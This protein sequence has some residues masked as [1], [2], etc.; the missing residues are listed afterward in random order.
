MRIVIEAADFRRLSA[1]TQS[2]LL[3]LLAGKR[4]ADV[5]K[6]AK[7][8]SVNW[9]HPVDLTPE[10]AVKL[11][12]GLAENHRRRLELFARKGGRVSMKALLAVTRDTDLRVLS[13]FQGAVSRKLRRL[14]GD[15]TKQAQLLGW[16]Y[17]S[18]KWD[19]EHKHII[20]G[21]YYVTDKTTKALEAYFD[22]N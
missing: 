2:E 16:D 22:A 12:H 15:H 9:R 20:N 4:I 18:T 7:K 21:I 3:E 5:A 14:L 11:I 10:L 1:G 17:E 19:K 13:Y 6:T 8:P